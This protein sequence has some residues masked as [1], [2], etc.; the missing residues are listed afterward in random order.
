MKKC[1][2]KKNQNVYFVI[3]DH[4]DD[5]T[6]RVGNKSFFMGIKSFENIKKG[7]INNVEY[8]KN[9]KSNRYYIETDNGEYV[10]YES[11]IFKDEQKALLH[12]KRHNKY[13]YL[14]FYDELKKLKKLIWE[15]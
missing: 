7:K 6:V 4:I 2:F 10:I 8:D 15:K 11:Y 1:K 13:T 14:E 12:C 5:M 9:T 3:H